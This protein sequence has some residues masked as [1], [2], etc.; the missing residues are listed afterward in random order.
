M[1]RWK[2]ITL[3]ICIAIAFVFAFGHSAFAGKGNGKSKQSHGSYQ[4]TSDSV[5]PGWSKGKK[6]GWAGGK[7][8]PGWSKWNDKQKDTWVYDRD[9]A[10]SEIDRI[11][12]QYRIQDRTRNK[13][14][15]AFD[16]AIVGGKAIS[17]SSKKLIDAIENEKDRKKIVADT[18]ETVADILR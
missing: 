2:L 9:H 1:K 8:P 14:A 16:E 3:A 18:M 13:I 11:C 12:K 17:D 15:E 7:Y 10:Q 5:P 4:K 6:T